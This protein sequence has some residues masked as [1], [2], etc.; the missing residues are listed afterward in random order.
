M[1]AAGCDAEGVCRYRRSL[2][3]FTRAARRFAAR[4][5]AIPAQR[6]ADV[7]RGLLGAAARLNRSLAALDRRDGVSYPHRT[8]LSE[9]QRLGAAVDCCRAGATAAALESLSAV[10][11]TATGRRFS[12]A[13]YR[14]FLARL[15][16][17]YDRLGPA[18]WGRLPSYADVL[19][20]YR[21]VQAGR[22]EEAAAGLEAKRASALAD[23]EERLGAVADAL[24]RAAADLDALV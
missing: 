12:P 6:Y 13:T 9:L 10:S 22:C 17:S 14:R 3:A 1:T 11:L 24:L 16:P 5:E 21:A 15:S 8:Q 7:N 18:A 4:R 20:E 19:P 23:L 2:A